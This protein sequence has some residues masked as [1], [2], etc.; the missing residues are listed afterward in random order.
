MP[1]P[2]VHVRCYETMGVP[3]S[4]AVCADCKETKSY[5]PLQ[6]EREGFRSD[7]AAAEAWACQHKCA[8]RVR[9]STFETTRG[10]IERRHWPLNG[11]EHE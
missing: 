6:A 4:V 3:N 7:Y 8:S 11:T 5:Y 9:P 1:R 2:D 10:T